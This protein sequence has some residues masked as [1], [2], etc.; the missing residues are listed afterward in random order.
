MPDIK[1]LVHGPGFWEY[2]RMFIDQPGFDATP[3]FEEADAVCWTGGA[4]VEPRLYGE[5]TREGT[6]FNRDRDQRDR[7]MFEQ[8]EGLLRLGI[9]RGGQFLNVMNGGRMYQDINN[10]TRYHDLIDVATGEVHFV[11]STHH[12]EMIPT[13]SG[14][15][16]AIAR[17]ATV[18]YTDS[19]VINTPII[20]DTEAVWYPKTRSLCYQPHPE[21]NQTH[22]AP[23]ATRKYFFELIA[24]CLDSESK[25]KAG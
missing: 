13:S 2:A 4:D 21:F 19:V 3:N 25:L 5:R 1:V 20:P 11:T 9:C 24:R 14:K 22:P 17:Q 15:V 6:Y 10:H 7:R 18:K 8:T 23:K 12:Q 16:L